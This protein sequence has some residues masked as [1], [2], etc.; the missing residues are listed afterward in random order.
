MV[1]DGHAH[2]VESRVFQMLGIVRREA[3]KDVGNVRQ[4]GGQLMVG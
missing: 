2:F 1:L 3:A 4:K